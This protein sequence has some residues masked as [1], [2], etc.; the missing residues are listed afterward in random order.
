MLCNNL[1]NN[2]SNDSKRSLNADNSSQ[3]VRNFCLLIGRSQKE[4]YELRG[5]F[6][7]SFQV[8]S[9]LGINL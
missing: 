7:S 6:S 8:F 4:V 2:V 9:S 5:S 1:Q 3:L